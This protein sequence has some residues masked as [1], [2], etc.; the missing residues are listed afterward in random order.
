MRITIDVTKRDID[1]GTADACPVTL[2]VRRALGVRK[3]SKLG[4]Y[5][6]IGISNICFLDED[7][8]FETDLAAMP[9]I[10]Q[11]FVNDFDRG[12][13]VAPFSFVANF[14]QERAKLVGLTLPTK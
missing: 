6:L 4:R 3:D 7:G 11:D 10:A 1:R 2:A 12:R 5:L 9:N 13:T 8:W 14:N